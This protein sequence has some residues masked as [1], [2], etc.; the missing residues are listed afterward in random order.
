MPGDPEYLRVHTLLGKRS[1]GTSNQMR[2]ISI[3]IKELRQLWPAA[4]FK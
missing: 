4:P 1:I 3:K 2:R